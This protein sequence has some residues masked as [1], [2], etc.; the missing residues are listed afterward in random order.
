M[1]LSEIH[2]TRRERKCLETACFKAIPEDTAPRL[3]RFKLT[4][5][6]TTHQPGLMPKPNGLMRASDL[7]RDYLVYHRS[8]WRDFWLKSVW[9][10][11]L[12]SIA[13]TLLIHVSEWLL[14]Q[15]Q[16]WMA[17]IL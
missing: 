12:V 4:Y 16:Q 10:P 13:T 9:V 17:S 5:Q 11:I 6:E 2:L 7:G 15:I 14:P 8:V 1:E 3:L